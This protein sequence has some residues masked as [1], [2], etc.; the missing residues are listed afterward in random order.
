MHL[1]LDQGRHDQVEAEFVRRFQL[2][3]DDLDNQTRPAYHDLTHGVIYSAWGH[4]C[5]ASSIT[6]DWLTNDIVT[7][8]CPHTPTAA[9]MASL[10]RQVKVMQDSVGG[11]VTCEV[12]NVP[13]GLGEPC[14]DKLEAMLAHAM[15]SLPA[16]KGF[17]I[18]SGFAG[19]TSFGSRHNDLFAKHPTDTSQL[20]TTSNYAGGTLGG[21][22]SGANLSFR[23]AIKP[24]ST[25]GQAQE[26]ANFAGEVVTLEAKGRH[27]P[28]VLPRAVP[29]VE[30]MTALVLADA[31]LIQ[32]TRS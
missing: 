29:L 25:I 8:R 3:R 5:P 11:I 10:I 28:C 13:V 20:K 14:F 1:A 12:R 22:S 30:A 31:M 9:A 16:T 4:V 19:T 15:L 26:T 21:I 6:P 18:G 17:D 27:D 32:K 24:V 2:G 7:V 23:V